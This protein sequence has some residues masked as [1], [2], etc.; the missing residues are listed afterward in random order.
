[1]HA[2]THPDTGGCNFQARVAE[3]SEENERMKHEVCMRMFVCL[4]RGGGGC[5]LNSSCVLPTRIEVYAL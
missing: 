3:L 4:G 1:M 5:L 2:R